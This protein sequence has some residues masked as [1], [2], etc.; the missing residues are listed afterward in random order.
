MEI[1]SYCNICGKGYHLCLSCNNTKE[2]TPWKIYTDTS[3]HYKIYQI[4]HGYSVG[5][6]TKNEAKE[7]LQN[8]DLSDLESLRDNI[9]KIIK[10]IMSTKSHKS[11]VKSKKVDVMRTDENTV[12]E[13][14]E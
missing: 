4:I 12:P 11:K 3:E 2:L 14:C 5:V 1:N 13:K 8:V 9:K 10:D 6:Y 7:K